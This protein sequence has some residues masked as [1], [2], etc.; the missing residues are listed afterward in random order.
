MPEIETVDLPEDCG[1]CGCN[2]TDNG[3]REGCCA[4]KGC[5]PGEDGYN[6]G[7]YDDGE[8]C[9]CCPAN[10]APT[11]EDCECVYVG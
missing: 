4:S 11:G 1:C 9:C 7:H 2:G 6:C 5:C 8:S 3:D 10:E